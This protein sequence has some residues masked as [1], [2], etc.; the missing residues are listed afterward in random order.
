VSPSHNTSRERRAYVCYS[1]DG[2]I[3]HRVFLLPGDDEPPRCP[4]HG[5]M[6]R[7]ANVPYRQPPLKRGKP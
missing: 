4:E 3:H 2:A 1:K 7:Q 6:K 5:R